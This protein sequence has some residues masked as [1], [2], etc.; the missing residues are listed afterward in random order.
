MVRLLDQLEHGRGTEDDLEKLLDVCDNI[1]GRAFCALGDSATPPVTSGVRY[2]RDEF[3]QH[4]KEGGCPFDPAASTVW[5]DDM[6]VQTTQGTV[7]VTID[8]FEIAVPKGMLII[9]AAELLGIQIP[10]FCDHPL[11]DPIGA[12]RQ[13]L[14]EV[15]GQVKPMASCITTCTEGMV[16]RTQLTSAVADKAQH[17]RDGAAAHQPPAGLP[18]VRQ[19][20]RVPAAEPGHV[21][22]PGRDPVHLRKADLRKAGRHLHRSAA[23]PR[24]LYLLH[25]VHPDVGGDRGGPVHRVHRARSGPD[26][27]HR[28]GQA[29]QLLLLRQHRA[30]LPGR[31]AHRRGVP[32]PVPAVRPGVGAERVR[33]LRGGM[34]AAH[35]H[36]ARAGAPPAG[37]RGAGRQRGVELRQGPL[38]LHLRDAAR[39]ADRPAGQGRR[40]GARP[41]VLAARPRG[42][43]GRP[44]RGARRGRGAAAGCRRADRRAAHA[45]GR[46]RVRQVRPGR[47]GHQRRGHAGA[48]ALGRGGGVPRGLRGR[49]RHHGQLRRPGAGARR[50]AGRIRA[51]RR[52]AHRLPPPAQGGAAPPSAGVLHRGAVQPRA[53]QAVRRPAGHAARGRGRRAHRAHGRRLG[54]GR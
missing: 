33:A 54:L 16:V 39:P 46:L 36:P 3:L 41:G 32:V 6:T 47:P 2:F 5:S 31:R 20:R 50:A 23:G 44:G 13:C 19:G 21:Q 14:V 1:T 29:V 26:D 8:G 27:R 9:R 40:R 48:G 30:G 51:R 15:E 18:D 7:T 52:V 22:R 35:R 24:A 43:R 42:G 4:Q 45:G 34:P 12:C 11:L 17:G 10:R 38:G 53:G 37:G 28:R 25:P 49:A